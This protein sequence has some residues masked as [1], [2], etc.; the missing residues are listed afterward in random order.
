MH[1]ERKPQNQDF[2]AGPGWSMNS[3]KME[4]NAGDFPGVRRLRA[5]ASFFGIK[6]SEIL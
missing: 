1:E 4:S 3:E 2:R 5:A 6:A